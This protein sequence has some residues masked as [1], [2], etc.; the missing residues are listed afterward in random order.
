MDSVV[1]SIGP[2][3]AAFPESSATN[4]LSFTSR[5]LFKSSRICAVVQVVETNQQD[6]VNLQW[7]Y[8]LIRAIRPS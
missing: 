1:L 8:C 4:S 7:V 3:H 5:N 6:S 2:V